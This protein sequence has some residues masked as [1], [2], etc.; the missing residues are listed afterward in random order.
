MDY[1]ITSKKK[2]KPKLTINYEWQ[3]KV[4]NPNK[5]IG[6]TFLQQFYNKTKWQVVNGK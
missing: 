5:G 2:R 6:T 1:Y 3:D 4:I